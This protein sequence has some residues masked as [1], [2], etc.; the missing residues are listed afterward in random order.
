MYNEGCFALP[1]GSFGSSETDGRWPFALGYLER[2]RED[3]YVVH[4]V[5][6]RGE[7][8]CVRGGHSSLPSTFVRAYVGETGPRRG[9][10]WLSSIG[11]HHISNRAR[12]RSPH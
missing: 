2:A 5:A 7:L 12:E 4:A 1:A 9:L 6:S 10:P 11:S 3:E 8:D